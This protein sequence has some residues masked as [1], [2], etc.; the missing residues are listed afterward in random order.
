MKWVDPNSTK[1]RSGGRFLVTNTSLIIINAQKDDSGFY[2]CMAS[3]SFG[4]SSAQAELTV[5]GK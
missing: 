3:N 1:I 4:T 2:R 5:L